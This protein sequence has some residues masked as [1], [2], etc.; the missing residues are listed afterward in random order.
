MTLT[1][2]ALGTWATLIKPGASIASNNPTALGCYPGGCPTSSGSDAKTCMIS[3]AL[4]PE[5]V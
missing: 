4:L 2:P 1:L 3:K 5:T